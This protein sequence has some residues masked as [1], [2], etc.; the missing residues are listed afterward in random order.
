MTS[1]ASRIFAAGRLAL[2]I[3]IAIAA[4]PAARGEGM[5]TQEAA[6][7]MRAAAVRDGHGGWQNGT[8]TLVT[9]GS[10]GGYSVS[11]GAAPMGGAGRGAPMVVGNA[12]GSPMVE[13]GG[14]AP[15]TMLAGR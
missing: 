13:Y 2:G 14:A 10:G 5:G 4:I 6:E 3:A 11:Y 1:Q 12:D 15:S 8:A 9:T 7:A